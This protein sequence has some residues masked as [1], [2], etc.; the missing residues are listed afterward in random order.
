MVLL[1]YD[2]SAQSQVSPLSPEVINPANGHTYVLLT[3][4]TWS[5]AESAAIALGGHLATIRNQFEQDW[6]FSTFGHYEGTPHLLWLGLN[7]AGS[8]GNFV[9]SSGEHVTYTHWADGE[10]NNAYGNEDYVA[11]FYPGHSSA[12]YWNDWAARAKDPIGLPLNGV[13]EIIRAQGT[14]PYNQLVLDPN[15]SA[16]GDGIPN[17]WKLQHGHDPFDRNLGSED[18]DGDGMSNLQEYLAGTD[19]TNSASAFRIISIVPLGN[20]VCITWAMGN[21]KTNAL[22]VAAG[23]PDGSYS[24]GFTDLFTVTNT[25]GTVTNYLD[26]GAATNAT[27]RFYRVRLVP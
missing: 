5:N 14:A 26:V 27:S 6:V 15:L 9:W 18:S 19:P 11:M 10:P 17:G 7:D 3:A 16:V 8:K 4:G 24:N 23:N 20:D 25:I 1:A 22:Q 12:S 21:G 2:S 13:V